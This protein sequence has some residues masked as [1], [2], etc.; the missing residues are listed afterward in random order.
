MTMAQ[1]LISDFFCKPPTS[2]KSAA[3]EDQQIQDYT[4][5][6]TTTSLLFSLT[7]L[8]SDTNCSSSC[9]EAIAAPLPCNSAITGG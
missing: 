9:Q 2:K 8:S 6:L 1:K 7:S 5:A 4:P 3:T